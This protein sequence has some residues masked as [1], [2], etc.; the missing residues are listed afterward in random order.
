MSR[1]GFGPLSTCM[2][3]SDALRRVLTGRECA[4][5]L[6]RVNAFDPRTVAERAGVD[7]DFVLRL[8]ESGVVVPDEAGRLTEGDT[9]RVSIVHGLEQAGLP[10]ASLAA[11]IQRGQLTPD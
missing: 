7:L 9:R 8:V 6:R 5:T 4:G 11:A 2:K 10:S 3:R 1:G